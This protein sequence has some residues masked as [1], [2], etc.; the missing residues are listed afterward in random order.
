M[1]GVLDACGRA[2]L[3]L[4]FLVLGWGAA[5]D[6]AGRVAL[7][8]AMG[9]PQ[10]E[11]AVRANGAAMVAAGAAIASGR[12]TAP[13]GVG[14]AVSLVPTTWAAH[15]YWEMDD[16]AERNTNRIHFYKNVGLLGAALLLAARPPA[17]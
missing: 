4:P 6:P 8:E 9:V 5:A 1:T 13:A 15:R 14:L 16:P 11:L 7:A 3:A 12:M 2:A 10:P 17:A